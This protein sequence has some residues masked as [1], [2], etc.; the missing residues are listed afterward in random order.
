MRWVS[1]LVFVCVVASATVS[2]RQ[3][4]AEVHLLDQ[5]LAVAANQVIMLSDVRAFIELKLIEPPV[6]VDPAPEVLTAVIERQLVLNEVAGWFVEEPSA[7]DID[8]RL[9]AVAMRLGGS[10]VLA[11]V[12]PSVGFTIDDLRQV[13]RDDIRVERYLARRFQGARQPTEDE[14]VAYFEQHAGEFQIDG[15]PAPFDEVRDEVRRRVIRSLRQEPI[16]AWIASLVQRA[17]IVRVQ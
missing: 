12:L 2:G 11:S 13:L 8:G 3:V 4:P 15:R 17:D 5:V 14:L 1:R 10:D 9:A 6:A 16:D 7:E